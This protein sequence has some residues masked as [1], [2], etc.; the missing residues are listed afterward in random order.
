MTAATQAHLIG[1]EG[2]LRVSAALAVAVRIVDVKFSYGNLRYLVA[3][4]A[5]LGQEW[6]DAGRVVVVGSVC[7]PSRR[8][9]STVQQADDAPRNPG[10]AVMSWAPEVIADNSGQWVGNGLRFKTRAEAEANVLHLM[11]RW[12]AVRDTR[13]VESPDPVNYTWVDGRLVKLEVR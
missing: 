10:G 4:I 7:T 5:G 2:A 11:M 9:V 6:V 3:P 12:M 13:V 1:R 8:T